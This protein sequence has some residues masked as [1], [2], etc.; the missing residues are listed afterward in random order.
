MDGKLRFAV[1]LGC[2]E[3]QQF[4]TFIKCLS[5]G[6]VFVVWYLLPLWSQHHPNHFDGMCW[7]TA[8]EMQSKPLQFSYVI[9]V[10]AMS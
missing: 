10:K 3:R 2:H 8:H 1:I 4:G 5:S 9:P 6:G 7:E